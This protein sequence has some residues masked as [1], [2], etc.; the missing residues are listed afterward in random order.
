M[1]VDYCAN[2]DGNALF[3]HAL[4]VHAMVVSNSVD[5]ARRVVVDA[6]MKALSLDSGP[7]QLINGYMDGTNQ[8]AGVEYVNGGDEHGLLVG[9]VSHLKVGDTVRL[10]P[11]HIDPTVNMHHFLVVVEDQADGEPMVVEVWDI[12]GRGPGL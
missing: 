2:I 8:A 3:E 1:D 5:S 12:S 10:I 9:Q 6:G 4:F 11:G 7:P